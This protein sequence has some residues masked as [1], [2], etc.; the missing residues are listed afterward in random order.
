MLDEPGVLD[1]N[2]RDDY[3]P[4]WAYLWP[5]AFLL[6]EVVAG[7]RWVEGTRALEIGCGLGLAG[8]AG[9]RA[10][11]DLTFSD[12]DEAPLA[13]VRRSAGANGFDLAHVAT[14]RLDWRD[15]PDE[16]FG[17]I[18]GADVLYERRLVPLVAGLLAATLAPGGVALIADPYRASAEGFAAEVE[19]RGLICEAVAV[20]ADSEELGPVRGTLHRVRRPG[21]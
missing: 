13:F 4:Y 5:G 2:R 21:P 6:A 17:V 7:E 11:L 14:R 1:W 18:L 16:R 3:M 15:P 10:G 9:V 20:A 19:A 8:L 12:Y